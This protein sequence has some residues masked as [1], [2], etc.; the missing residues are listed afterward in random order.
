MR[1]SR[2]VWRRSM[3]EPS[4]KIQ[5]EM[6][7]PEVAFISPVKGWS[8]RLE[9]KNVL[10]I[11]GKPMFVWSLE[12]IAESKYYTSKNSFV[13][14][15]SQEV[16]DLLSRWGYA[17]PWFPNERRNDQTGIVDL[18]M[19]INWSLTYDAPNPPDVIC[20]IYPNCPARN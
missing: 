11:L 15:E 8:N 10:E 9:R 18:A 19:F 20:I 6:W 7:K 14:T 2:S 5:V 13:M 1:S 17:V 12:Q 16:L 4:P 3:P